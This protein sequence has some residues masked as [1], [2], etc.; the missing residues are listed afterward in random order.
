MAEASGLPSPP[1]PTLALGEAEFTEEF[2]IE[3]PTS[4]VQASVLIIASYTVDSDPPGGG[5]GTASAEFSVT[6]VG[7][8][9]RQGAINVQVDDV[10]GET[11]RS[12]FLGSSCQPGV[13][14]ATNTEMIQTVPFTFPVATPF[15]VELRSAGTGGALSGRDTVG[16][17]VLSF[18]N[19]PLSVPQGY[20]I[21]HGDGTPLPV[22]VPLAPTPVPGLGGWGLVALGVGM[23]TASRR[24]TRDLHLRAGS[25]IFPHSSVV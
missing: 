2:V 20:T 19:P 11:C 16:S 24:A 22:Y 12:G 15:Q 9:M 6:H 21:L 1:F 23:M 3:G 7:G 8:S 18:A 13:Y 14:T 4:D 17:A 5:G 10:T 25:T